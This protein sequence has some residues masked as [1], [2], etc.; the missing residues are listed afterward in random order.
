MGVVMTY[1]ALGLAIR[2]VKTL[3]LAF[4]V[5][6]LSC[7]AFL[8]VG[9]LALKQNSSATMAGDIIQ[10]NSLAEASLFFAPAGIT[11]TVPCTTA[12]LA[13]SGWAA[14]GGNGATP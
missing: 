10:A 7:A 4:S 9:R 5:K 13:R 6:H 1:V 12:V 8:L 2:S 14:G 3:N 11:A